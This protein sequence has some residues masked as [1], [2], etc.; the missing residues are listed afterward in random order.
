MKKLSVKDFL[1][2]INKTIID[3]ENDKANADNKT[4]GV[5]YTPKPI[6]DYIILKV[7]KLFFKEFYNLPKFSTKDSF[8]TKLKRY[9]YKNNFL[10]E[11]L[12]K[13]LKTIK[14]LDPACGS[15]RFLLSAAEKLY[16]YYKTLNLGLD[17]FRIKSNILKDNL[18]G[19][20]I[21][22][23]AY[24]ITKLRLISWLFSDS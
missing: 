21:E 16:E 23:S 10:E 13:K 3:F 4:L 19:I 6:V 9:L 20:E 5:I 17:N 15:G 2:N 14:I 7:L 12:I 24:I 11:D 18:Y 1:S 8:F 22:K